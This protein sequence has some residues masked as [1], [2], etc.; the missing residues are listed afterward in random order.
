M[1]P[2]RRLWWFPLVALPVIA[3][4]IIV[5]FMRNGDSSPPKRVIVLR[6]LGEDSSNLTALKELAP[7]YKQATGVDVRFVAQTFDQ[8]QKTADSSLQNGSA[9]YDIILNYNFSL[10]S[11][12]KNNWV[13][14]LPELKSLLGKDLPSTD[15]EAELFENAWREVG[16]YRTG[17]GAD[18]TEQA[19]GYP[20]AANTMLL[21]YNRRLFDDPTNQ[22]EYRRLYKEPLQPPKTWKQFAQLARFFT[23]ENRRTY[24]L[25]LQGAGGG[26]QYY[27]WVNF[28]FGMGGGVM[29]KKWGWMGD[30]HTPLLLET[31]ETIAATKFY[32]DLKP[33][34]AGD[35]LSTDAIVQRELMKAGNVAMAIM[36][37]DY[38]YELLYDKH[39]SHADQ[40]G[41]EPIPGDK[42]M[43]AGGIFYV[44]RKSRHSAEA[45]KFLMYVMQKDRQAKLMRRGL[46][47]ALRSAYSDPDV[48]KL[49]YA[50]AL[51]RS[52][53]RG[54]Y[55]NEANIDSAAVSEIISKHLQR[56]WLG[57]TDVPTGLGAAAEDINRAQL[58][59]FK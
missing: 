32:I 30:E 2:K 45:A 40:F 35:Y 9:L 12:V 46:C 5:V 42:S 18:M 27:E 24:G 34:T 52:L 13:Y 22:L 53:D 31:S 54:V 25:A 49:P 39:E 23:N 58:E 56:M 6:I 21:C 10:A 4:A 3:A 19:I 50:S 16:Y 57:Q 8:L 15:F 28:A 29:D 11:Y 41:F 26:W 17:R 47:S 7:E 37:S 59:L 51:K 1:G 14:T 20:F 44:N 48:R 38:V 36:W 33:Y 55:M 43:L